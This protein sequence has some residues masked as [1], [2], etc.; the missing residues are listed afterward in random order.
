M[1]LYCITLMINTYILLDQH[2]QKYGNCTSYLMTQF[3]SVATLVPGMKKRKLLGCQQC[4]P[5]GI[6]QE[7]MPPLWTL[8]WKYPSILRVYFLFDQWIIHQ[9]FSIFYPMKPKG[10]SHWFWK[11]IQFSARTCPFF[12]FLRFTYNFDI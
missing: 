4:E 11:R 6:K 1:G 3:A 7:L 2:A 8:H 5:Q 10:F 12:F 9:V